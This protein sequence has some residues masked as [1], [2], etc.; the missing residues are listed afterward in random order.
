LHVCQGLC[1]I[2]SDLCRVLT[3]HSTN[4]TSFLFPAERV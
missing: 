1:A 4:Q 3:L 2:A